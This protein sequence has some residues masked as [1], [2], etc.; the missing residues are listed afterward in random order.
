MFN[1]DRQQ[2]IKRITVSANNNLQYCPIRNRSNDPPRGDG[3]GFLR[4]SEQYFDNA[5]T[6]SGVDSNL[7]QNM[8]QCK[9]VLRVTFPFKVC[10]VFFC[11]FFRSEINWFV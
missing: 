10:L 4:A 5:A 9:M 1:I 8:K 2:L 3:T 6:K 11:C 7:L